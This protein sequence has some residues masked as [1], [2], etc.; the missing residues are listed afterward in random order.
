MTPIGS[1]SRSETPLA[2]KNDPSMTAPQSAALRRSKKQSYRNQ[3][4]KSMAT[5]HRSWTSR[6]PYLV[7]TPKNPIAWTTWPKPKPQP[8]LKNPAAGKLEHWGR[9]RRKMEWIR[10]QLRQKLMMLHVILGFSAITLQY[11]KF[12]IENSYWIPKTSSN[13]SKVQQNKLKYQS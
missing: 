11:L 2:A 5:S 12:Q 4:L 13:C 1:E 6:H 9:R 7:K 10:I 8:L 3:F